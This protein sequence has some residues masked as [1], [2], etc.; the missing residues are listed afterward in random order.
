VTFEEQVAAARGARD[1]G[2]AVVHIHA[3]AAADTSKVAENF[4]RYREVND[5]I[6]AA[7][8][9]VLVDNT[10][11]AKPAEDRDA[12]RDAYAVGNR[13]RVIEERLEMSQERIAYFFEGAYRSESEVWIPFRD[14]GWMRGIGVC[15]TERTFCDEIFRLKEHLERF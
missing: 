9:E 14:L 7:V 6:R 11:L 1:S 15:D 2:A 10:Q 8:P 12:G 3:R 13:A 4:G 5:A